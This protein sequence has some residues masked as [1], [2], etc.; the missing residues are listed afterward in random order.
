MFHVP[1]VDQT[2]VTWWWDCNARA[3]KQW[4]NTR[5]RPHALVPSNKAAHGRYEREAIACVY[6]C[7]RREEDRD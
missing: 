1:A 5:T 3:E 4:S 6:I 2:L 7:A